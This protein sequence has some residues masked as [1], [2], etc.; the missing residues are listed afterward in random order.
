MLVSGYPG[1]LL[2][3]ISM[4]IMNLFSR[5]LNIEISGTLSLFTFI[6]PK[7]MGGFHQEGML[8]TSDISCDDLICVGKTYG[9]AVFV[10]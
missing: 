4:L 2:V 7:K 6:D 9:I 8:W 1:L 10:A 3:K 5:S